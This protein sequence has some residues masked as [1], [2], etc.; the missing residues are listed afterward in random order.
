VILNHLLGKRPY[1]VYLLVKDNIRAIASDFD[2]ENRLTPTEFVFS[3]KHYGLDAYIERSKSKGYH[4]WI[5]FEKEG[6]LAHKARLVVRH[7]LDETEHSETEIFPKQDSLNNNTQCGNFINAPLFGKLVPR[8]K[9]VF[10]DRHTFEPYLL[11]DVFSPFQ[12]I[13][14]NASRPLSSEDRSYDP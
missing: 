14:H 6:V 4:V 10:I 5:F 1:G 13:Y 2:T 9:T 12:S 8:G 3:A 7:I 11:Q